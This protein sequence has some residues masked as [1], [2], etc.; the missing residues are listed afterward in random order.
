ML[1]Q[2]RERATTRITNAHPEGVGGVGECPPKLAIIIKLLIT[3]SPVPVAH[4]LSRLLKCLMVPLHAN[5]LFVGGLMLE[6]L[7]A[8]QGTVI[9]KET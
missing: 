7:L 2:P 5:N 4:G 8:L 1:M 3:P 6:W 9:R